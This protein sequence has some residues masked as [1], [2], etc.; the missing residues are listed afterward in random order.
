MVA[1]ADAAVRYE[2]APHSIDCADTESFLGGRVPVGA[3]DIVCTDHSA[4]LSREQ[5]VRFR[6]PRDRVAAE[7]TGA[8][9]RLHG[10]DPC[11]ADLCFT[12]GLRDAWHDPALSDH[13]SATV[14]YRLDGTALV[15]IGAYNV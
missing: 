3:T 13:I 15:E 8:F 5:D 12:G 10:T 11:E 14:T 4:P 6:L 2:M 1:A 7:L 9:P